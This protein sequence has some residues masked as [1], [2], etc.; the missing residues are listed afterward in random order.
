MIHSFQATPERLDGA[1]GTRADRPEN[2][3]DEWLALVA[4]HPHRRGERSV[5]GTG[6]GYAP[7]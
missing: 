2:R 1:S 5:T 7:R 3:L 6:G 4:R